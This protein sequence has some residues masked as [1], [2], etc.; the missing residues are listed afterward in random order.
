MSA[1]IC[2]VFTKYSVQNLWKR[3]AKWKAIVV[4]RG[5]PRGPCRKKSLGLRIFIV[6]YQQVV[7]R[8][9]LHSELCSTAVMG[10]LFWEGVKEKRKNLRRANVNY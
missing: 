5:G 9:L 10:K 6:G 3:V 7:Y 4:D 2:C 1:K 8:K